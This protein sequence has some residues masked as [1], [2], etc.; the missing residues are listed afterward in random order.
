MS[1]DAGVAAELP[2]YV[3]EGA[4]SA[5]SRCKTCRRA[6]N[7]GLLRLGVLIEGPYGTGYLWHHLICAARRRFEMVEAAYEAEAWKAAK[8]PPE[9]I[10]SL[11]SLQKLRED[12]EERRKSRKTIP[13]AEIAPTGRSKCKQC[14]KPIDQG[15]LRV[16]LGRGVTFG[17]QVRTSPVVVHPECV[18]AELGNEDCTTRPE[19]LGAALSANSPELS[20][21]Q[22]AAL[23]GRLGL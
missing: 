12:A 10:P 7:K 14:G 17:S 22:L 19:G 15:D 16:V 11:D 2:A 21:E 4:R 6:I 1:D 8:Q 5:R 18:A 9:E 20:A 3:I 23:A 13:Y